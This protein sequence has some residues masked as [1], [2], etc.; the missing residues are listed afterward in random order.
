MAVGLPDSDCVGVAVLL[1]VK[2][3]VADIDNEGVEDSLAEPVEDAVSV[4]LKV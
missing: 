3:C 4:V 2:V 1:V